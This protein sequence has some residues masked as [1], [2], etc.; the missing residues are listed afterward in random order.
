MTA[1]ML[2]RFGY[3]VLAA[4]TPGEGIRLA[5]E[6]IGPIHLVITDVIMPEMN[7]RDLTRK[8]LSLRPDLKCLFISGY[9]ADVIARH[10]VLEEGVQLIKKPFSKKDL[11]SK[12]RSVLA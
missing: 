1:F 9:T 7:G 6:H 12:I 11:A 5:E 3:A 2:E 4:E 8:L 10:G